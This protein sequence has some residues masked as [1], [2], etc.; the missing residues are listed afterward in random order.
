MIQDIAPHIY[1]N[2]Y[3]PLSPS[4]ESFVLCFHGRQILILE[5]EEGFTFPRFSDFPDWSGEEAAYLFSI[6]EVGFYFPKHSLEL[7]NLL[8]S[9]PNGKI[10]T[11][12]YF[13]TAMPRFLAF[14]AV[15]GHQLYDWY[16][17]RRYCGYCGTPAEHSSRE[18]AL[19]C[20]NCG[21]VEYP[22][23]C[24]AVIVGVRNND[25]ILL[26]K[27]ANRDYTRY[28][29]VAGF[30]EIGESIEDT[31][32]REV[33]EEV[34]LKVKNLTFYKSQPWSFSDTLLMGF[35]CD[36]D[37]D[38]RITLDEQELSLAQWV[39]RSE[40]PDDPEGISLTREMMTVFKKGLDPNPQ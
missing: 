21:N 38:G 30:A 29:L 26:T 19:V 4:P 15:T 33:M 34:G 40:V 28:A 14:A 8:P 18:R 9:F 20:P 31:V 16:C 10:V 32:R 39:D 23:I 22:K 24:P 37:G 7:E 35:F 1:H 12:S 11:L 17:H 6:D 27:Y 2:E 5:T 3:H 36:V 25:Q 13:R